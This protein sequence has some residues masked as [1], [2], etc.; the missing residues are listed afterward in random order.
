MEHDLKQGFRSLVSAKLATSL[1]GALTLPLVVRILGPGNYGDYA[2][3]M[4]TFSLLMLVVTPAITEGVQKFVAED[5]DRSQ[6]QT[7]VVG[8][9]LRLALV[10]AAIGSLSLASLSWFGV[11][12]RFF[13][14]R[15]T[16][17]FYVL[18]VHVVATQLKVF[19]RH[20]LLGL[21]LERYSEALSVLL[22]AISRGVGLALAFV[23]FGVAG[24]LAADVFAALVFFVAGTVVLRS[25]I[26][27]LTA[28][29]D[30]PS[31][32][33]REFLSFNLLNVVTVLLMMSLLHVDV[34][35]V[36]LL[37]GDTEAGFY[38]AALVIAQYILLIS[39]SLQ[40]LM[41]HSASRFWS[42]G[43]TGRI[44]SLASRL[45][46]YVLLAT[47]LLAVGILV[48]ADRAL[49]LYFGPE[50]TASVRPL[51]ILLPGVVGFALA[52][53]IYG[54]NKGSGRLV[55]LV[56]ALGATALI[57]IVANAALIPIYGLTGAALATSV[58]YGLMFVFQTGCAR[59]I[60]YSPVEDL[61]PGRLVL[62]IATT[63]VVLVQ[64]DGALGSDYLALAVVP[65]IG[66]VLFTGLAIATGAIDRA[67]FDQAVTVLPARVHRHI[68]R[69]DVD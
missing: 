44:Q 30:R 66:F 62:T 26:S 67:E 12:E 46:R 65:P 29:R 58:S 69:L 9:Y 2:F 57:N 42:Q 56:Y 59:Y 38:K 40:S 52:R 35:M 41:L 4:S 6:W 10:L 39:R 50:F 43:R 17:F 14:P 37:E 3:L 23:G 31:V 11:I 34:M 63:L 19:T 64:F 45:T 25:R 22:K 21:G 15:F 1:I 53:P 20:T 7:Q 55:P 48:L 36:R 18:S 68:P 32:S 47:A 49:P 5:R 13:D 24:F 61:R 28:V 27:L 16:L 33:T 60:G 8:F 51:S 54:I